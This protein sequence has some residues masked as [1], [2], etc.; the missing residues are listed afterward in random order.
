[1]F[2]DTSV[3][4]V[5][6]P[7]NRMRDA[8]AHAEKRTP[9]SRGIQSFSSR[10]VSDFCV[11][12]RCCC[13]PKSMSQNPSERKQSPQSPH[14][15][16]TTPTTPP[17]PQSQEASN[18]TNDSHEVGC[19]SAPSCLGVFS[20]VRL[21]KRTYHFVKSVTSS[22]RDSRMLSIRPLNTFGQRGA[23]VM[24]TW[25]CPRSFQLASST[26]QCAKLSLGI[27]QTFSDFVES[28]FLNPETNVS[29]VSLVRNVYRMLHKNPPFVLAF[30]SHRALENSSVYQL[31]TSDAKATMLRST[32]SVGPTGLATLSTEHML[33]SHKA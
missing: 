20:L 8:P 10:G 32:R 13:S 6:P 24:R 11:F 21:Q 12:V 16:T 4:S 15:P 27:Q 5:Q 33:H 2:S 22:V 30:K 7:Q 19:I 31:L 9:V 23:C 29:Y 3:P 26:F 14:S 1:M 18:N 25:Q 17:P 28:R